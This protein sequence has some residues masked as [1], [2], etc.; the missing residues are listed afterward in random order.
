MVVVEDT[1]STVP[2]TLM[3][4]K[5]VDFHGENYPAIQ[6]GKEYALRNGHSMHYINLG[7]AKVKVV[8]IKNPIPQ[9]FRFRY[10]EMI[11]V[12]VTGFKKGVTG[13]PPGIPSTFLVSP[14]DLE[15]IKVAET[16]ADKSTD[17]PAQEEEAP[18]DGSHPNGWGPHV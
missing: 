14:E 8:E 16:D 7:V 9:V 4:I 3:D 13:L 10:Y 17:P 6:L 1:A 12:E 11:E 15:D 18:E 5:V 2:P